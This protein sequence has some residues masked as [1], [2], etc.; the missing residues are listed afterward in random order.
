MLSFYKSIQDIYEDDI[1]LAE[2]PSMLLF[3]NKNR[4]KNDTTDDLHSSKVN[5]G[6]FN[7]AELEQQDKFRY[8]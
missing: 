8:Q 2:V 3:S 1:E 5:A 4:N 7:K 6:R